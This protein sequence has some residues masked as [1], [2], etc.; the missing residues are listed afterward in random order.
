MVIYNGVLDDMESAEYFRDKLF[1]LFQG[2]V[3]DFDTTVNTI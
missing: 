2:L 3:Q 1:T